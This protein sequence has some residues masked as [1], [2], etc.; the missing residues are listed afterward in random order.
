[1]IMEC[2]RM[3]G[4]R[5]LV[6][7]GDSF[8]GKTL[9]STLVGGGHHVVTTT[10]RPEEVGDLKILLD[11][12][13][14]PTELP[15]GFDHVI[16]LAGIWNYQACETSADAWLVN[17]ENMSKIS[18]QFV[19]LGSFVTFVSSN[20]VFGGERPWCHEDDV[21]TPKFAYAKHK[22]AGEAAIIEAVTAAKCM[23]RLNIVRLTKILSIDT[24]PL[25][26]W[27]EDFEHGNV[28][29]PFADLIFAPISVEFAAS[30]VAKVALSGEPGNFHLSG[31][32]NI[33]Y[34]DFS[35]KLAEQFGFVVDLIEA[36]TSQEK[37]VSI[38]FLPK[39]SGL[40]MERTQTLLGIIPQTIDGVFEDLSKQRASGEA[41]GTN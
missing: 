19:E 38:P 21:H 2:V 12:A 30:G 17:V 4:Q 29:T 9:A 32:E 25:P 15:S 41:C 14:L 31:S 22:A 6:V 13:V 36:T 3:E 10:R 34:V 11:L 37:G 28:V 1:M 5:I 18:A 26:N 16:L 8:L 24:P 33:N 7:G 20:T 27:L 35:R 39:Y 40:G 23:Q